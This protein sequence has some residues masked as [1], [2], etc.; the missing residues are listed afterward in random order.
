MFLNIFSNLLVTIISVRIHTPLFVL[1]R[2]PYRV[3][4]LKLNFPPY[5]W[6]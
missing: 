6:T 3:I 5:R 4:V 2:F 1:L